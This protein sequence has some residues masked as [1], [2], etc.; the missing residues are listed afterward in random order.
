MNGQSNTGLGIIGIGAVL[1]VMLC[2]GGPPLV[3]AISAAGLTAWLSHSGYVL[4]AAVLI[5]VGGSVLWLRH[6]RISAHDCCRPEP[7][8]KASKHE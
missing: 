6:H 7:L 8:N 1:A 5:A 3:T 2:C 4:I